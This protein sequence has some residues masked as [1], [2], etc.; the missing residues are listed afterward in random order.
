MKIFFLN[1]DVFLLF[2]N[3]L[4][5]QNFNYVLPDL[6]TIVW[7][8]NIRLNFF[9]VLQQDGRL[10]KL[11]MM[12]PIWVSSSLKSATKI[13]LFIQ[14]FC[15]LPCTHA[16]HRGKQNTFFSSASTYYNN[17]ACEGFLRFLNRTALPLRKYFDKQ[18]WTPFL[19]QF[20]FTADILH[21][22]SEQCL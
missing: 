8:T 15:F 4:N 16:K 2:L 13:C 3:I 17:M 18:G 7:L 20:Q 22:D 11:T 21:E 5:I 19:S 6:W 12:S 9:Y 10:Q 14:Q 1:I